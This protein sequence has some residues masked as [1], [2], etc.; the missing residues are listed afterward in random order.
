MGEK[1]LEKGGILDDLKTGV[2]KRKEETKQNQ[3]EEEEYTNFDDSVK[4]IRD[5]LEGTIQ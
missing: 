3:R 5:A 2:K 4:T 1:Y